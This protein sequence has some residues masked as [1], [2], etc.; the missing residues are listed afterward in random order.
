MFTRRFTLFR[1]F[2][3]DV[4]MD[5]SWLV[6]VVLVTWSLARGF[7]PFAVPG[8]SERDY[9]W[10][11]IAGMLGLFFSIV[12]HELSHAL[13]ARRHG[14]P[15][16]GVTL[17]IFGGVAEMT[18]EPRDPK[19]EFVMAIA[20]PIASLI[21]ALVFGA[22]YLSTATAGAP[23]PLGGVMYYLGLLNVT[24]AFFNLVPA[25]PLDGGRMLRAALWRWKGDLRWATCVAARIG[26]GFGLALI[27]LGVFAFL[28]G[29]VI[30][31]MWWFL[32]G[33]FLRAAAGMSTQQIMI[34]QAMRGE[35]V[36]NF[37]NPYP[38]TVSP[39]LKLSQLVNN[40][41]YRH[42]HKVYPVVDHGRLVGV[43]STDQVKQVPNTK[44][45]RHAVAEV[46]QPP[47]PSNTIDADAD[48]LDAWNRMNRSG[49]QR[50]LIVDHDRLVGFV[51][52]RDMMSFMASKFD[53]E[54][55][56]G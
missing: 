28:N 36:R 53:L 18:E 47:T 40:Y 30:G 43:V 38:I 44:W 20:G 33:L 15:V 29:N 34:R 35:P 37:M 46:M 5:Y 27:V 56:H 3:V 22:L 50:L 55:A 41:V 9:G 32:I 42:H 2:G 10:M 1:L 25:F 49:N 19:I 23:T 45:D 52:V 12:F 11:A 54:Q 51:G 13:V 24:L 7:F 21:L 8:L 39:D 4:R 16:G 14:L 48:A 6:L 31:G 26:S 17:F